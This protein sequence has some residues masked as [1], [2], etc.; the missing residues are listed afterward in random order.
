MP[1]AEISIGFGLKQH[2]ISASNTGRD[3]ENEKLD[4]PLQSAVTL[5]M[6]EC[7]QRA[8]TTGLRRC[9]RDAVYSPGTEA[10][11]RIRKYPEE[12]SSR[13]GEA[14]LQESRG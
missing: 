9:H 1:R 7:E 6:L 5:L 3:H 13:K 11:G 4:A 14:I 2:R 8:V 10:I 12:R